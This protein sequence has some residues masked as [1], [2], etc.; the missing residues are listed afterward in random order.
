MPAR[1]SSPRAA[2]PPTPS[3][4]SHY[5]SAAAR[6]APFHHAAAA[7]RALDSP[8][9]GYRDCAIS[10]NLLD[11][12][13]AGADDDGYIFL[14]FDGSAADDVSCEAVVDDPLGFGDDSQVEL[15]LELEYGPQG[16]CATRVGAVANELSQQ[17]AAAPDGRFGPAGFFREQAA[18]AEVAAEQPAACGACDPAAR[19][20]S[21]PAL[22]PRLS[23]A[24]FESA[25]SALVSQSAHRS[26]GTRHRRSIPST[27]G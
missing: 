4:P 22:T 6:P 8:D 10:V 18:C 20:T 13:R 17:K 24:E 2:H 12:A 15:T 19:A 14:G 21:V 26:S 11:L 9:D 1:P 27:S 3:A 5:L 25:S 7:R 16:T 23:L